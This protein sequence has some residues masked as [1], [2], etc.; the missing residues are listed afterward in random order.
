LTEEPTLWLWNGVDDSGRPLQYHN[1]CMKRPINQLGKEQSK[2]LNFIV[3]HAQ[4]CL[5]NA[6]IH[7]IPIK[8]ALCDE[9]FIQ[10]NCHPPTALMRIPGTRRKTR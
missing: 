9:C 8:K 6:A 10:R 4:Y 1:Q 3:Y 5:K 2:P 7:L